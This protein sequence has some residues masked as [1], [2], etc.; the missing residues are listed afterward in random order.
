MLPLLNG[1]VLDVIVIVLLLTVV[2][3]G[4][5]KGIKHVFINFVL[6]LAS[7]AL[8]FMPFTKVLKLAIIDLI[9]PLVKLNASVAAE[10]KLAIYMSYTFLASLLLTLLLYVILRLIKVFLCYLTKRR[11]EKANELVLLTP[12]AASRV[13]GAIFSLIFNGAF[14]L[15]GL[16][17]FAHPFVGGNKTTEISYVTKHIET[18]PHTVVDLVSKDN[19]LEE[20][21]LIKL[22]KGDVLA[23]VS[24]EDA[25]DFNSIANSVSKKDIIPT[26]LTTP[27]ED[28]DKLGHLVS[29]VVNNMLDNKKQEIDGYESVV[30]LTR[31]LANKSI[32]TFN[33]L[34]DGGPCI[35][36]EG[37][38]AIAKNLESLGLV[39]TVETFKEAFEQ[40]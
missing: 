5:F 9:S 18:L 32:T 38:M 39:N 20:K 22:L 24:D 29:F 7:L 35:N 37:T 11:K 25:K 17:I 26:D 3:I 28:V 14:I 36:T 21:L 6:L 33:G 30:E 16:S 2:A 8:A 34:R 1:L 4:A 19:L 15:I 31:D 12:G 27:Q 23:K 13:S 10:H 40:R